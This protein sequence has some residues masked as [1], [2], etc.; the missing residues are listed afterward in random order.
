MSDSGE[1]ILF[2][3]PS[4]ER[5]TWSYNPWRTRLLLAYKGLKYRTEWLEYP[6]I[7]TRLENHVPNDGSQT[8][9]TVPAILL[10]DGTYVMHSR[11]ILETLNARY[12]ATPHLPYDTPSLQPL[13][14]S[15][16]P[17]M[18]HFRGVYAPRVASRIL[19]EGSLEYFRRTRAVD[20]EMDSLEEVERKLGG[21]VAYDGMEASLREVTALLGRNKEGPFFE[22]DKVAHADFVWAGILLFMKRLGDDV[23]E[24]V[25]RRSGDEGV[26]LALLEAVKP[27]TQQVD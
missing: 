8:P 11:R 24:E 14:N 19:G 21:D 3:I 16:E 9:Y 4:K 26:H 6:E 17:L 18:G 12:P 15:L 22:G 2:D 13:W 27:W 5:T 23:F 10:P 1:I 20:F 7:R 25:M